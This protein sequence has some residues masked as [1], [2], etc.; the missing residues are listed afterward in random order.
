MAQNVLTIVG[1]QYTETANLGVMKAGDTGVG[2]ISMGALTATSGNVTG[3]CNLATT[4]GKVGIGNAAPYAKLD[5]QG[6]F[7]PIYAVHFVD[8][9]ATYPRLWTFGPEGD[10]TFCLRDRTAGAKRITITA[11]GAITFN[12][13][14]G[15]NGTAAIAKPTITGSR[16][17]NAA[18]ASLLTALASYGLITDST[19]A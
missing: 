7:S 4:S 1:G 17:G 6:D 13:S 18:L 8:T 2:N 12:A 19:T 3:N 15:F 16:A 10:S 9:N 11:A 14:V 5:I